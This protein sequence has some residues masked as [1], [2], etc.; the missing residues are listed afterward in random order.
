VAACCTAATGGAA[1]AAGVGSGVAGVTTAAAGAASTG[2]AVAVGV[3]VCAATVVVVAAVSVVAAV[4]AIVAVAAVV[5]AA[6]AAVAVVVATAAVAVVTD[7]AV[8]VVGCSVG[9]GVGVAVASEGAWAKECVGAKIMPNRKNTTRGIKQQ[10][11]LFFIS[12]AFIASDVINVIVIVRAD[13]EYSDAAR[14]DIV[15]QVFFHV[16]EFADRI[17]ET[18]FNNDAP[19]LMVALIADFS[20]HIVIDLTAGAVSRIVEQSGFI[21]IYIEQ[22][23]RGIVLLL[24]TLGIGAERDDLAPLIDFH[25]IP[26]EFVFLKRRINFLAFKVC[27]ACFVVSA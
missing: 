5:T 2:H 22:N 3:G 24:L 15:H 11:F 25:S 17:E 16:N 8:A 9:V 18:D 4:A 26:D 7:S 10:I 27:L 20:D 14:G 12:M 1:S 13:T 19:D 23:N 6:T 21:F